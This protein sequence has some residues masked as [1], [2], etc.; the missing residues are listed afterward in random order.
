[1]ASYQHLLRSIFLGAIGTAALLVVSPVA[2]AEEDGVWKGTGQVSLLA[3]GGNTRSQSGSMRLEF[4]NEQKEIDR[5]TLR[6]GALVERKEGERTAESEYVTGQYDFFHTQ[7]TYSLYSLLLERDDFA[8]YDYRVT[9]R[10]GIGHE[11]IKT[12]KDEVRLE[13]GPD[14]T[15]EEK[16]PDAES[17]LGVRLYG[18]YVHRFTDKNSFTQDL[19]ILENVEETDDYRVNT[20]TA[21]QF[22][23]NS[24]LAFK[25]ALTLKYDH[26]PVEG[27][28]TL[29]Y[30]TETAL[31]LNF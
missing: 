6:A 17:F 3:A 5:I 18:K 29:D 31:V 8:G 28:Q 15:Y 7:R 26:Q 4:V 22:G 9:A 2:Q 23:I 11:L 16:D 25:A 27:N 14:Y 1:M 21:F 24:R 19:E 10:V 30:F 12:D 13:A 20:Y